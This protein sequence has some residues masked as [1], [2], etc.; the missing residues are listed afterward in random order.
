MRVVDLL[1][2]ILGF[3]EEFA[4]TTQQ[5]NVSAKATPEDPLIP[6][7]WRVCLRCGAAYPDGNKCLNFAFHAVPDM[8]KSPEV[9]RD[10]GQKDSKGKL[11]WRLLPLD[12]V[13]EVVRVLMFGAWEK[14][15]PDGS[16]GYGANNW[17]RVENAADEYYD[18]AVRHLTEW[19]KGRVEDPE[20]KRHVLAHA[21][22][23]TLFVLALEL[24]GKTNKG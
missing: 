20:S 8:K 13:E 18:A 15:R 6:E 16:K 11:A 24:R 3:R 17:E 22:C 2:G 21:V 14:V 1:D 7:G 19:R 23:A 4:M 10:V 5:G 12:A 9:R